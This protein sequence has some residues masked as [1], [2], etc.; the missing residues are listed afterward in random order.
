MARAFTAETADAARNVLTIDGIQVS[1]QLVVDAEHRA[2]RHAF[3]G[4]TLATDSWDRR[5][6]ERS[7]ALPTRP[8]T[9][10][11]T[12]R[13]SKPFWVVSIP[14]ETEKMPRIAAVAV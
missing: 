9:C 5:L 11:P 1:E 8:S 6:V 3:V 10:R 13:R 2:A 14:Q 12:V 7:V 4:R